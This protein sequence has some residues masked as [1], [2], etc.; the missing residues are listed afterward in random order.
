MITKK[1]FFLTF[2]V[3]RFVIFV[4]FFV[5]FY[6]I[7]KKLEMSSPYLLIVAVTFAFLLSPRY[8]F[9]KA[10]SGN[11]VQIKWLFLRKVIELGVF[12]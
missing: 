9:I 2:W 12:K 11:K 6:S 8:Q 3:V 5:L 1:P 7:F 4:L 10:Q